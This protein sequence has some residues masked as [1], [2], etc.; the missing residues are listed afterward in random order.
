MN[1][2]KVT[3]LVMASSR[4]KVMIEVRFGAN[5]VERLAGLWRT[6]FVVDVGLV[7]IYVGPFSFRDAFKCVK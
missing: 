4:G 6:V 1:E 2:A 7:F 5:S 3:L